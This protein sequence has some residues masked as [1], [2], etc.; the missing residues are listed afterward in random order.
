LEK[1]EAASMKQFF[2]QGYRENFTFSIV[3]PKQILMIADQSFTDFLFTILPTLTQDL[4]IRVSVVISHLDY[5]CAQEAGMV[6]ALR[7]P[8]EILHLAELILL[9]LSDQQ[10]PLIALVKEE[11]LRIPR[12]LYLTASAYLKA[13][14]NATKASEKLYIH[15]NTFRYRLQQF[16]EFT[17]LDIRDHFHA[18]Y[19]IIG[20]HI[21]NRS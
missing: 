20:E 1:L 13:G 5:P 16:I 4:G 6:A 11:F 18:L 15:R 14:L 17:S 12:D 2:L 3:H 19:F 21:A 7:K 10:H 9:L 8:S